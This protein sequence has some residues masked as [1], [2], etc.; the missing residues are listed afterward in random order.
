MMC[1][2]ATRAAQWYI[3]RYIIVA[4]LVVVVVVVEDNDTSNAPI[5]KNLV[6][7]DYFCILK[8]FTDIYIY[9]YI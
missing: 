8:P 7:H 9:M 3:C 5:N 2:R 6:S 1:Y 4:V